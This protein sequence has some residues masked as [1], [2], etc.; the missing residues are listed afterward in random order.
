MKVKF[1]NVILICIFQV[2][3]T[4]IGIFAYHK[5]IYE[6]PHILSTGL[7]SFT[8]KAAR[9][10]LDE[11]TDYIHPTAS[12]IGQVHIGHR[13]FIAPQASIRG[14][15]GTPIYIGDGSNVQDGV[16]IHGLETEEHNTP[17]PS[18]LMEERKTHKKYAVYVGKNV[19]L[20]HQSQV[21]GPAIIEDNTFLG[22]QALVFNAYVDENCVI[23]PGAKII[24]VSIPS[25]RYIKAG[26]IIDTQAAADGLP[27]IDD[28]YK[29]KAINEAVIHLNTELAKTYHKLYGY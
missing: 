20:A 2:S 13:V 5:L 12:I 19:S 18:H 7:N 9:P 23:E 24:G 29:L 1:F 28:T 21:H 6:K 26:S 8:S 15:E 25:H 16:V 3:I 11:Q 17:I 10:S 4:A 27:H 14:D 22:M